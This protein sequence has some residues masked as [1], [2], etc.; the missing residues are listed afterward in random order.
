MNPY[1]THRYHPAMKEGQFAVIL[2][3]AQEDALSKADPLW[4]DS[5]Y[6]ADE[7]LA[8]RKENPTAKVP[9]VPPPTPPAQP[10]APLTLEGLDARIT[11]LE[12]AGK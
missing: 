4:R 2:D 10:P 7:R 1:P 8:Y 6:S 9:Q 5:E 12:A 11:K 3:A